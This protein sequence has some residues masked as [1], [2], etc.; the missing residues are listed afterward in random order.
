MKKPEGYSFYLVLGLPV[1]IATV[2]T[3]QLGLSGLYNLL[4]GLIM[5]LFSMF[6][7][8]KPNGRKSSSSI[9]AS[10]FMSLTF[11]L[12]ATFFTALPLWVLVLVLK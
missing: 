2:I 1:A 11:V 4:A 12:I 5:T 7:Y 10:F 8:F 3:G 6:V 9:A